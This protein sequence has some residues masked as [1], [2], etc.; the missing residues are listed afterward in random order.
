MG[1]LA[2]MVASGATRPGQTTTGIA[3]TA[4][5]PTITLPTTDSTTTTTTTAEQPIAPGVKIGGVAVGGLTPTQAYQAVA[6]A[7]DRPL[8]L[9]VG[10]RRLSVPPG[11][12]GAVAYVLRSVERAR[13]APPGTSIR[14]DVGV[15][16]KRVGAWLRA[17]GRRFDRKAVDAQLSLRNLK[18]YLSRERAGFLVLQR[19]SSAAIRRAIQANRRTPVRLKAKTLAPSVTRRNFGPVIVIH[20]GR[21]LLNLYKGRRS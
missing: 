16:P 11:K 4:S 17:L 7:F 18:P 6:K 21:N 2:A 20:R 14:L 13:T 3:T 12:F 5:E 9:L 15:S 19:P 10:R 8:V 1:V